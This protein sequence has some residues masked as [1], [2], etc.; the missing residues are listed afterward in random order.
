MSLRSYLLV[1]FALTFAL[2]GGMTVASAPLKARHVRTASDQILNLRDFGAVGDG[3][4][5]DGPALQ[6]ALDSLAAQGGGTL[7]VPAGAYVIGTPVAKYFSSTSAIT[8]KGAEPVPVDTE[9]IAHGLGLTSEFRVRVSETQNVLTL[10]ALESLVMQDVTFIGN[11][12]V[13]ADA[14]LVLSL[15]QIGAATIR[16][17][18]F[19]GLASYAEGGA[20]IHADQSDLRVEDSAFLGCGTNS[21]LNASVIQNTSW[22]SITVTGTR[23]VDFGLRPDFF[24]KTVLTSPY[25]WISIGNAAPPEGASLRREVVLRDIFLD[26]GAFLGVSCRPASFS[27]TYTPINLIFISGL[28]INVTNLESTGVYLEQ[29]EHVFIEKSYFGWSTNADSAIQ[30]LSVGEAILDQVTCVDHAYRIRADE[31]TDRL[32]VV[33]SIYHDLDS[34]A[35]TTNVVTTASLEDDPVQYVRQQYL[36]TLNHEP[37]PHGYFY[38][39]SLLLQCGQDQA[40]LA[41]TRASLA[42]YLNGNSAAAFSLSGRVIESDGSA[43]P[44]ATITLSGPVSGVAQTDSNGGYSFPGLPTVGSY[45]ITVARNNYVFEAPS[46]TITTPTGDQTADFIGTMVTHSISGKAMTSTGSGIAGVNV[47]LSGAQNLTAITDN[48]GTYHLTGVRAEGLYNI[49]ASR[50]NYNFGSGK[51]INGLTSDLT[52]NFSATIDT[53]KIRGNAGVEG[54]EVVLSGDRDAVVQTG[55]DGAY[56]FTVDAEGSYTVRSA[57]ARYTFTPSSYDFTNLTG[58]QQADFTPTLNTHVLSGSAGIAGA[59]VTLSGAATSSVTTG[60]D[61]AYLFTVAAGGSYTIT[62]ASEKYRFTP[63]SQSFTDLSSDQTVNFTAT[64][65]LLLLT[66]Y[67]NAIA[68]GSVTLLSGPFSLTSNWN[69]SSDHRTRIMIFALNLQLNAGESMS[70]VTVQG[71]DSLN[72]IYPMTVELVG[73]VAG[74]PELTQVNVKLPDEFPPGGDLWINLKLHDEVSN[75]ARIKLLP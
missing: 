40:C 27:S 69:F 68:L 74:H 31:S 65:R 26:E 23:F 75:R 48:N 58:D 59:T 64:P 10:G 61:G 70:A 14:Q 43:I 3:V 42:S 28:T 34:L 55:A 32:T 36:M 72:R 25:S 38:W 13:E 52:I 24:S 6:Q 66:E 54:A 2:G 33:N 46:Q 8:I 12:G 71:E 60:A 16:H 67:D 45:S 73:P 37:D 57:K 39:A 20:I 47:V 49:A 62:P 17:C 56:S 41:Q 44:G 51:S 4:T 18:E 1:F 53:F 7:L 19:Y 35:Q 50:V 5:D 30:L 21:G 22:R 15:N 9:P 63:A 29:A 11:P